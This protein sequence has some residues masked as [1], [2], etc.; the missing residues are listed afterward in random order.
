ML[1][2]EQV[3]FLLF[4]LDSFLAGTALAALAA[5]IRVLSMPFGVGKESALGGRIR[6]KEYPLIGKRERKE[7]RGFRAAVLFIGD[8][9]FM[10]TA[11]LALLTVA[12]FDNNGKL[13]LVAFAATL[14]GF[15]LFRRTVGRATLALA[16]TLTA[17]AG[18]VL[19]YAVFFAVWPFSK[20]FAAVRGAFGALIREIKITLAA[21]RLVAGSSAALKD[22]E[23]KARGGFVLPS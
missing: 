8:F 19:R 17:A 2:Y 16:D 22:T 15:L 4:L 3:P 14:C 9:F 23:R 10:L 12:Y 7:R 11:A 5:V 21:K 6:G 20:A 1:V 18:V 13:R